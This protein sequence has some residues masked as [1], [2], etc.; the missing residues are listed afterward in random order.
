MKYKCIKSFEVERYD[1]DDC[2][3]ED[4]QAVEVGSVW[5]ET[6]NNYIGGELHL[7]AVEGLRWLEISRETL[8][9]YFEEVQI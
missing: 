2:W 3:T 1:D 8:N 5:E 7:E 4:Y 9:Q 6:S